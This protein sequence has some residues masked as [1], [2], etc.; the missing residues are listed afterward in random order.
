MNVAE[1]QPP[2]LI[3]PSD[4]SSNWFPFVALVKDRELEI[5]VMP[6]PK[7]A[8]AATTSFIGIVFVGFLWFV[9]V[10]APSATWGVLAIGVLTTAGTPILINLRF[11]SEREQGPVL[12]YQFSD[13][14]VSLPRLRKQI[15]IDA[16]DAFAVVT[17]HDSSSDW[18]SQLQLHTK[19]G[20]R[21]PLATARMKQ[22]L[23]PILDQIAP[24]LKLP[25]RFLK[26]KSKKE[27][28]EES[29]K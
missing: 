6:T 16:I 23:I 26:Q 2:F 19:T 1:I 29:Q 11:K 4:F 7:K 18:C 25:I 5:G 28:R 3:E 22:E 15:P 14:F 24:R 10:K 13:N 12:K 8:I 9:L 20:G 27:L 17:A 21:F